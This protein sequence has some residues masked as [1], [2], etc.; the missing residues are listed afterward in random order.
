MRLLHAPTARGWPGVSSH[1][2]WQGHTNGSAVNVAGLKSITQRCGV[3]N[4][5]AT[6][7]LDRCGAICGANFNY[8]HV[9]IVN[10]RHLAVAAVISEPVSVRLFPC[11]KGRYRE[12]RRFRA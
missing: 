10:Q 3:V 2:G 8:G 9:T 5:P 6:V 12:I 11:S 4:Q 1:D 7:P